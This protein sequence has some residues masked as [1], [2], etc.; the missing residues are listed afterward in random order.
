MLPL[1]IHLS[2]GLRITVYN[3]VDSLLS[4]RSHDSFVSLGRGETF[5]LDP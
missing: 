5:P 1:L 3:L 2:F 4:D